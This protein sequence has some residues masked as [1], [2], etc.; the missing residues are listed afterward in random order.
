MSTVHVERQGPRLNGL[1]RLGD[2]AWAKKVVA[3]TARAKEIKLMDAPVLL[4][5]EKKKLARPRSEQ[6]VEP[7]DQRPYLEITAIFT[8]RRATMVTATT[9]M[10]V[11]SRPAK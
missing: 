6:R 10:A 11:R 1:R 5:I 8:A 7:Q 4:P 2:G 3:E 9:T